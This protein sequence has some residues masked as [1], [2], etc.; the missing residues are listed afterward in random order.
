MILYIHGFGSAGNGDKAKFLQREFPDQLVLSPDIPVDPME[1]IRY[2]TMLLDRNRLVATLATMNER[3]IIMG[4]S[5][6]GFYADYIGR[7][8]GARVILFNPS[9]Q[10]WETMANRIGKHNNFKTGEEFEVTP[11]HI[12]SF[13]HLGEF[14]DHIGDPEWCSYNVFLGSEDD[15]ID[16]ALA[17]ERFKYANVKTYETDHRFSIFE[18]VIK[19][20]RSLI[21]D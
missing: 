9:T 17:R 5:L 18:D 13:K 16:P 10:P 8:Y 2:L 21:E 19:N 4:T 14:M 20:N 12:D 7:I 1:A 3:L 11:A 15:Q 6:G